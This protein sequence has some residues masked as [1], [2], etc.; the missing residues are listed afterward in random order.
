[1][2]ADVI[3]LRRARKEREREAKATEAAANRLAFG[4]SKAQKQA[5]RLESNRIS[6]AVD[7]ARLSP[8]GPKRD[9]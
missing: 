5:E 9:D 1:M 2:T 4:R 6:R 3:N 7:G 8:D